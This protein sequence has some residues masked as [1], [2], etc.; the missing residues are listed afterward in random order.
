MDT[1]TPIHPKTGK[2]MPRS[3][4][5]PKGSKN[6]AT[7]LREKANVEALKIATAEGISPLDVM[8]RLMRG[9][10]SGY[11]ELEALAR[12]RPL[13]EDEDSDRRQALAIAYKAAV[14]AAPYMHG[15][16]APVDSK[17]QQPLVV[18]IKQY[19]DGADN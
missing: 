10:W 7:L 17:V 16:V 19:R 8:L 18:E 1:I 6:K 13:T 5:R 4:G 15:K 9:A 3:S 11:Y 12:D 2:L 14:D